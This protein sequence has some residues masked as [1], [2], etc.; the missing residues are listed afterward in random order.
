MVED[1]PTEV[2]LWCLK[3]FSVGLANVT[4]QITVF[5]S[6]ISSEAS[7]IEPGNEVLQNGHNK[8]RTMAV[9]TVIHDSDSILRRVLEG[10]RSSLVYFD[11]SG[12]EL[13]LGKKFCSQMAAVQMQVEFSSSAIKQQGT[14]AK[15]PPIHRI[16]L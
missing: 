12:A 3:K 13:G 4:K 16:I 14:K 7:Q 1:T 2:C 9:P 6:V 10:G 15:K 11:E 5:T 8:A